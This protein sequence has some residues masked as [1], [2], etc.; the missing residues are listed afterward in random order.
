M[1]QWSLNLIVVPFKF[2]GT[3]LNFDTVRERWGC[4]RNKSKQHS[5]CNVRDD[6]AL[7]MPAMKQNEGVTQGKRLGV[8]MPS[9]TICFCSCRNLIH[10]LVNNLIVWPVLKRNEFQNL[11]ESIIES[12]P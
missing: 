9:Q 10:W 8:V 12:L 7:G 6:L 1:W 2:I 4:H 11:D 5:A 3:H